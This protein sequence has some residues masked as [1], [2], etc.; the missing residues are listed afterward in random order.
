M[1]RVLDY[2]ELGDRVSSFPAFL[3]I[4]AQHQ[5]PCLLPPKPWSSVGAWSRG[6]VVLQRD[7]QIEGM[8][9]KGNVVN[10]CFGQHSGYGG[11]TD[12]IPWSQIGAR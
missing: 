8:N 2:S 10:L 4:L 9:F 7:L 6:Y 12:W 11:Y 1:G 5:A 3:Q